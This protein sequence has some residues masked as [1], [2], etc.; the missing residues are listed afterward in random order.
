MWYDSDSSGLGA[1]DDSELQK[2]QFLSFLGVETYDL[3]TDDLKISGF[4]LEHLELFRR[5][6]PE[7]LLKISRS[8]LNLR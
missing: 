5:I 8:S 1:Q 2:L 3:L 6:Q 4:C 7:L